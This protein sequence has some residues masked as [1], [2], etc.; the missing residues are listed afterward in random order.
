[1]EL[2][3]F[4]LFFWS[5][6]FFSTFNKCYQDTGKQYDAKIYRKLGT[7]SL[8]VV[9]L[10]T[11]VAEILKVTTR[12]HTRV[13]KILNLDFTSFT[14]GIDLVFVIFMIISQES[15]LFEVFLDFGG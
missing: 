11:L 12:W 14:K 4:G 15:L 1:M 3:I 13:W 5:K 7:S 6:L 8:N 10:V 2:V 9:F